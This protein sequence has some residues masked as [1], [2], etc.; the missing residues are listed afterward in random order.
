MKTYVIGDV[1]GCLDELK[2]LLEDKIKPTV[3]DNVVLLGDLV[4]RG[5]YSVET[6]QYAKDNKLSVILGN[7]DERYP[8]FHDHETQ[9]KFEV[10][11]KNPMTLKDGRFEI[12]RELVKRDLISY[13][14]SWPVEIFVNK[15][16]YLVHGGILDNPNK[17]SRK[18]KIRLR[19][20]DKD[21]KKS[22]RLENDYKAPPNSVHWIELYTGNYNVA[23]GHHVFDL[24]RPMVKT[25]EKNKLLIGLD[26]GCC[27]NGNLTAYCLETNEFFQVKARKEYKKQ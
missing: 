1:H 14:K 15:E 16:W 17:E 12:Y 22:S 10:G 24:E 18:L 9:K 8:R 25:T 21:T 5:P 27:F 2:E 26:T 23:F 19:F 7:H 4:D 20:V 13:I 11:Y 3:N 6:V